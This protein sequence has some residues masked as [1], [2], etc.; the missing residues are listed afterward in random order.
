MA[1]PCIRAEIAVEKEQVGQEEVH[2]IDPVDVSHG[3]HRAEPIRERNLVPTTP[4]IVNAQMYK[5]M[6]R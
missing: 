4:R 5:P 6:A 3:I 2:I 1:I